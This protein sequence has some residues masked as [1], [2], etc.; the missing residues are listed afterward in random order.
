MAESDDVSSHPP[1]VILGARGVVARYLWPR[2]ISAGIETATVISR[3]RHEL[4]SPL[5]SMPMDISAHNDWRPPDNAIIISLLPLWVLADNIE[6]FAN[7]QAIIATGSTSVFGKATSDD[8]KERAT[9]DLLR[10]AEDRLR[11]WGATHDVGVTVLRP[12]MIYDGSHDHNISRLARMIKRL[13]FMPVAYP[14]KGLRQPIHADDVAIAIIAAI[15]NP[16]VH[17]RF[18]NISGGEI[19]AYRDMIARIFTTL[20]RKP[21]ILMFPTTLLKY[22]FKIASTLGIMRESAFGFGMFQRM[23]EDLVFDSSESLKL[24]DLHPRRFTPDFSEL[25]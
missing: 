22:A 19:L 21:Y 11:L 16:A 17:G 2:L 8:P 25:N 7:V 15:N 13:K 14:A 18:M 24:L 10:Q 4:P 1:L 12:T 6:R 23:N 3:T 20:A 9:A 5:V